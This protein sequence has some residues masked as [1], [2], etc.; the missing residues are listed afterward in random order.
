MLL[1]NIDKYV[2]SIRKRENV[3][4]KYRQHVFLYLSCNMTAQSYKKWEL[5]IINKNDKIIK[6]CFSILSK[7]IKL[8]QSYILKL[9][10]GIVCMLLK[11]YSITLKSSHVC[12]SAV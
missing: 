7:K 6:P 2:F 8:L 5:K 1:S 10:L 4:S 11:E 3:L 9:F 12:R